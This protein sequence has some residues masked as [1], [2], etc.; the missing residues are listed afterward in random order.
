MLVVLSRWDVEMM[1]EIISRH[2]D[3][4]AVN[5]DGRHTAKV[6]VGDETYMIRRRDDGSYDEWMV[7]EVA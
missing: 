5:F 1:K 3:C 6:F 7:E 4:R 2:P